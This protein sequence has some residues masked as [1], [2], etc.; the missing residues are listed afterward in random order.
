MAT[1]A[2][3]CKAA[4]L[5][6]A[7]EL[8]RMTATSK[9]T[10]T[11][12]LKDKPMLFE[13]VLHG[14]RSSLGINDE[15]IKDTFN[16]FKSEYIDYLYLK[17]DHKKLQEK[18]EALKKQKQ[19]QQAEQQWCFSAEDLQEQAKLIER[20]TAENQ[21]LSAELQVSKTK[22]EKAKAFKKPFCPGRFR[23][24]WNDQERVIEKDGSDKWLFLSPTGKMVDVSFVTDSNIVFESDAWFIEMPHDG[25]ILLT[26][27]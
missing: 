10:L 12:W 11:N 26:P 3:R 13:I 14:A 22:L 2:E 8:T 15:N 23:F 19:P 6:S 17:E 9:E 7:A 20:L 18:Y 25:K 21:R 27:F 24:M 1:L 16:K 5:S 4:G